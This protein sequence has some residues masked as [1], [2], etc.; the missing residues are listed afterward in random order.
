MIVLS[1]AQISFCQNKHCEYA[2]AAEK[3]GNFSLF[4]EELVKCYNSGGIRMTSQYLMA[5]SQYRNMRIF[6]VMVYEIEK[7]N[8]PLVYLTRELLLSR[9]L[10]SSKKR[11]NIHQY[12]FDYEETIMN[13]ADT[14][15]ALLYHLKVE[16]YLLFLKKGVLPN[17][18]SVIYESLKKSRFLHYYTTTI[19]CH[20][21]LE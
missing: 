11:K 19:S 1:S 8:S 6:Q 17:E 5:L 4:A 15:D 12:L 20:A 2:Q 21:R 18:L 3:N 14:L 10:R 9:Q 7:H 13:S 16:N